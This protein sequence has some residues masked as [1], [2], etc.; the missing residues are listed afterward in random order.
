MKRDV[1][2]DFAKG[3][4]ILFVYLGHSIIYHPIELASLYEWCHVLERMIASFNLPMFFLVS[5]LL[6]GFSKKSW[7]KVVMDK[8]KRL[9]IPYL[10]TMLIVISSKMFLPS[11]MAY[12]DSTSGGLEGALYN[13]LVEGGDRWFVYVLMWIFAISLLL[14]KLIKT[15][16]IWIIL[17]IPIAVTLTHLA[18]SVFL[19]D[20]TMKYLPFFIIGMYLSGHWGYIKSKFAACFF[21]V[22]SVFVVLNIVFVSKLSWI[23]FV[24]D[25]ILPL[26]GTVC[27]MGL[28]VLMENSV[29]S[30]SS[31]KVFDF[32][33]Y[34]GKYSL[35]FY[36][37]SFA[38]PVIRMVIVN[39]LHIFNPFAIVLLVFFGQIIAITLIIEITRRIN[40]LK[41]PMGY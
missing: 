15:N 16:W 19:F 8:A 18:P 4:A 21:Y 38:Y 32:I 3:I 17:A 35:Q 10:F 23:P 41:I 37:F 14:R 40:F 1:S 29:L 28:A 24:W 36:L 13:V 7:K 27:F 25:I 39:V 22:F 5:G 12:H 33:T 2:I 11:S 9:L 31:N 6:F 30:K 20:L 34:C 26:V